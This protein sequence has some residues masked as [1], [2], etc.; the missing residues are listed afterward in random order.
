MITEKYK[1]NQDSS[2]N[3]Y[4]ISKFIKKE[5]DGFW[6]IVNSEFIS[7]LNLMKSFEYYTVTTE[8]GRP[9]LIAE[10]IYGYG[11]SQFWWII[12]ILN[13]CVLPS[14]I[15]TGDVL[16]YPSLSNLETI[17]FSLLDNSFGSTGSTTE[18]KLL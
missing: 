15:K 12:M 8:N 18:E 11:N 10:K 3:R 4:D 1:L 14:D 5:E 7:N 13:N 2:L 16:K 6:D 9:E 17:Y